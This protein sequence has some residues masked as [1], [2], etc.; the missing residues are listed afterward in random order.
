MSRTEVDEGYE[1]TPE[2]QEVVDGGL[3]ILARMIA[4]RLHEHGL[5]EERIEKER[6]GSN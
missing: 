1:L 2:R 5:A 3:R 4:R 6:P